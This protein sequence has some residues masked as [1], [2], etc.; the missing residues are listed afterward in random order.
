MATFCLDLCF[1]YQQMVKVIWHKAALLQ[2]TDGSV[3][4]AL[5]W[6]HIG[7]TWR[8]RLIP[9]A[10]P[11]PQPT[12]QIRLNLCFLQPARVHNPNGKSIG[13]AIFAQLTAVS[14][15]MPVHV[16]SPNNFPF[17]W[18][19]CAPSNRSTCFFWLTLVHNHNPNSISIGWAVFAQITA[20]Y[21][22][23]LKRAAPSP[24][25]LPLS[26]EDLDPHVTHD[27][28]SPSKPTTQTASPSV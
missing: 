11:S 8:T 10:S 24:L 27:S 9:L 12:W 26:M 21:R 5:P 22:Y 18:G 23:T 4:F 17:S 7:A 1:K 20:Q 6:G 16:L 25:K 19:I 28:L 14:S 2:Q 13:S 15:G 3:V